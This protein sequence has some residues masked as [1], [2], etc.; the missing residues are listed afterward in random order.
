VTGLFAATG[1][2]AA[3][4]TRLAAEVIRATGITCGHGTSG[5][6]PR[7]LPSVRHV[8]VT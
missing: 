6:Y 7:S 5:I 8:P 1:T 4:I 2:P 3:I